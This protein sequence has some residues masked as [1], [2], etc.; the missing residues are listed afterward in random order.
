MD[1]EEA[2]RRPSFEGKEKIR[3][4]ISKNSVSDLGWD[5]MRHCNTEQ[6]SLHK[7]RIITDIWLKLKIRRH[8]EVKMDNASNQN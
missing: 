4:E 3:S 5:S 7:K 6:A 8:N 1:S 2:G